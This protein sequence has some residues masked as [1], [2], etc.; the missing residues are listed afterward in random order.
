MK[1]INKLSTYEIVD[2]HEKKQKHTI[3][4]LVDNEFGVLARVIGLFSARG[5]N[6]ESLTV[7]EVDHERNL[8]RITLITN[9]EQHTIELIMALLEKIVPVYEVRDLT[10]ESPHI[11]R[12]VGLVKV[13]SDDE[14]K[15]FEA[16]KLATRFGA[17]TIDSTPESFIF[18]LSDMPE[19][20]DKFIALMKPLGVREVCRT[21]VTAISKGAEYIKVGGEG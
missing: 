16:I 5:Y 15:H 20:V 4:V 14:D 9:G 12:E 19:K 17:R 13:V 2:T 6:L 11:E 21:G 7:S 1:D 3:A 10:V 8:S 18:E